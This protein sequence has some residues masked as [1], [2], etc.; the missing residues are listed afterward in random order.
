MAN[1]SDGFSSLSALLREG[2]GEALAPNAETLLDMLSEDILFEFPYALPDG[3][4]SVEGKTAFTAYL[5]KVAGL[6]TVES[7]SLHRSILST[8]GQN[9]VLEFSC[10]GHADNENA[11]YDQDY[12]SVI[13]LKDGLI[14]RYRDY[15]NPLVVM[16]AFGGAAQINKMLSGGGHGN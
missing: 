9:A 4:H 14:S 6:L 2:L 10:K 3:I 11:R 7:M 16:N 13:D 8:D 12:V 1:S 15:W 5:Q